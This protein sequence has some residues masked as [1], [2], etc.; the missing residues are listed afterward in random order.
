MERAAHCLNPHNFKA[1]NFCANG[2]WANSKGWAKQIKNIEN[3]NPLIKK[4]RAHFFYRRIS[5][6]LSYCADIQASAIDQ[7]K[8][9]E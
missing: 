5:A 6:L 8:C 4:F 2:G 7:K 3:Y 9:S 1:Q